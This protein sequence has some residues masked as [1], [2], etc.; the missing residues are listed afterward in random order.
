MRD[1]ARGT[2]GRELSRREL[3]RR[4][5]V[6]GLA[7]AVAQALPLADAL[8][9]A[10]P[11]LGQTPVDDAT[12]GAFADTII[13]G[14]IATR[15][16]LGDVI[17]PGMIAGVDPDP[18]AVEA[19]AVRLFHDSRVGFDALAAPFV[20]DI[21]ARALTHGGPFVALPFEQRVAVVLAGL[22][23]GNGDRVL[24]EAAAAV[25]FTAFCAAALV[26]NATSATASGYRVM[27]LP[28]AAPHG[29]RGFSYRRRLSVE[30]T[31]N[32]SLP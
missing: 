16:D 29:Y 8:V 13:P 12:L 6:L 28:G 32:G 9:R 7:A 30:R 26:P 5:G 19:G 20:A 18:G 22:D 24:W 10:D 15:T 23:F 17:P 4:A 11:A 3:I 31:R 27:G 25:P 1:P 2:V 14:R 21:N